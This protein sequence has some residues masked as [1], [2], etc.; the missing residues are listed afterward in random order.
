MRFNDQ[1]EYFKPF[2]MLVQFL[3]SSSARST[4]ASWFRSITRI[5]FINGTVNCVFALAE[6][7]TNFIYAAFTQGESFS[8]VILS[9]V[10]R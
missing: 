6:K 2:R 8:S 7:M 5:D 3:L 10:I 9:L 4:N 1:F